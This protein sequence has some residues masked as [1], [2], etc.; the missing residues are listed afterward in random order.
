[1]NLPDSGI[2]KRCE[3]WLILTEDCRLALRRYNHDQRFDGPN[4]SQN[5]T[6]GPL[7]LKHLI[8]LLFLAPRVT[9]RM[10]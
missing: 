8:L 1:M 9:G 5:Y 10:L 7:A 4:L 3:E 2:K 6:L